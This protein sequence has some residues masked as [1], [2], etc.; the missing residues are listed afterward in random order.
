MPITSVDGALPY[1]ITAPAVGAR[2]TVDRNRSYTVGHRSEDA[3]GAAALGRVMVTYGAAAD[4]E[5]DPFS[6]AEAAGKIVLRPGESVRL[7]PL[8][9][10]NVAAGN[11]LTLISASGSPKVAV[12][13]GEVI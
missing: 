5:I 4:A 6:E 1:E 3:A 10:D 13:P 11:T 12:V 2:V 7:A 9:Q 8:C